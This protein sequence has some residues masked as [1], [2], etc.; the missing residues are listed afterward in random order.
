MGRRR[1]PG[2]RGPA[3]MLG[4]TWARVTGRGAP[5]A[6]PMEAAKPAFGFSRVLA[7]E[8]PAAEAA[9]ARGGLRGLLG[10]G[11]GRLLAGGAARLGARAG[12]G[13][14]RVVGG[15]A[16]LAISG[17]LGAAMAH[18]NVGQ[19][20]MQGLNFA[21]FGLPGLAGNALGFHGFNAP[22]P[23]PDPDQAAAKVIAQG[24]GATLRRSAELRRQLA[25]GSVQ[26][27][28]GARP[29]VAGMGGVVAP[30]AADPAT[31]TFSFQHTL[32]GD[33]R[34]RAEREYKQV[35][36]QEVAIRQTQGGQAGADIVDAFGVRAQA[37]GM[38]A[39]RK[40]V[41]GDLRDTMRREGPVAKTEMARQMA[42]LIAQLNQG[43]KSSRRTARL[44]TKTIESSF[45]KTGR[46]IKIAN[47]QIYTGTASEWES[48]RSAMSTKAEQARQEVSKSMTELQRQAYAALQ[49]MGFSKTEARGLISAQEQGGQKGKIAAVAT[50]SAAAGDT[51]V[52][53]GQAGALNIPTAKR[54]RG[55]RLPGQTLSDSLLM[56]DGGLGAPG[57]LVVNRH[58]EREHDRDARAAGLPTLGQRV[59]GQRRPHS[60]PVAARALGA[61]GGIMPGL[62]TGGRAPTGMRRGGDAGTVT[63]AAAGGGAG[64]QTGS[65]AAMIG[66]ANR[67][68]AQHYPYR[69]GGGHDANF[70][71]PYDCSGAVSMVLH[72]GGVL[73][74]P[75]TS[76]SLAGMFAPGPGE[77]S[78]YANPKH[79]Y[80]SLAGQFFGTSTSNPGGGAGWF[81]GGARPGFTVRHVPVDGSGGAAAVFAN[82]AGGGGPA[83]QIAPLKGGK[84][85]VGGIPGAMSTQA[86]A[87]IAA[88]LTSKINTTL[89]A[90]GGPGLGAG[91]GTVSAGG[92]Y[93]KGALASLWTAQGGPAG[94]ANLM[95]AI[96]LAES[97]GNARAHNPSGASGLWQIL[98]VPFAGDPFDP[99]TNARMAVSKYRSQGLGRLGGLHERHV[100]ALHGHRRAHR[101]AGAQLRR[102]VRRRRLRPGRQPDADR[103]RRRARQGGGRHPQGRLGRRGAR[104]GKLADRIVINNHRPGDIKAQLKKEVE[105]AFAE[106]ATTLDH[107]PL[108]DEE[109]AL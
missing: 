84:S 57:E 49:A 7:A 35:R 63:P 98:G 103:H 50:Q 102:V 108:E 60:A 92:S 33:A 36:A 43:D 17:V 82:V 29:R 69:W 73:N 27:E 23:P 79:T 47:G 52:A 85:G 4:R 25:A 20:A 61:M 101:H 67:I 72:A 106:L 99:A 86:Q 53:R 19:R 22:K 105:E 24:P 13:A 89:A 54:A 95:A 96:A 93:N 70:T 2:G 77:V 8:A 71:P 32:S 107:L 83:P 41:L 75:V 64:S 68:E 5:M 28:G 78:I 44:M 80:M 42:G 56:A 87:L 48:I 66:A 51:G 76:G 109:G 88:G 39:A 90:T 1:A 12:L 55:G 26:R 9:V 104:I 74:A 58:T 100:P 18:G 46:T 37:K 40:G 15:P 30:P 38:G 59:A 21:G 65:L 3:G 45:A 31:G 14:L 16:T 62:A 81:E 34:K 10:R 91:D 11:G 6:A 97:G 94:V